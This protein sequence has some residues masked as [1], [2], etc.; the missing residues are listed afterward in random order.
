MEQLIFNRLLKI[1]EGFI[2]ELQLRST[3]EIS[4]LERFE[5]ELVNHLRSLLK[6]DQILIEKVV[7]EEEEQTR[8]LYTS[9]DKYEYMVQQNPNLKLL[10]ERLGL[11]FEY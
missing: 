1:K 3:L 5:H 4:I 7:L 11:D 8:K 10:K 6:N 2:L 9:A